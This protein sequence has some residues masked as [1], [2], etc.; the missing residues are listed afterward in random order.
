MRHE[1]SPNEENDCTQLLGPSSGCSN[2]TA[3]W[4]ILA[5]SGS[6]RS[7]S[8]NAKLLRAA[9]A[10][11][12]G[13]VSV[14]IYTG[15]SF[16]P[17]FNP[18]LDRQPAPPAVADLRFR[19][20]ECDAVVISSPEY[21][22][23]IPGVLKNALD[24]VVSSGELYGKPVGLF[25]ASPRATFAQAA[26]NE[27][28]GVMGANIITEACIMVPLSGAQGDEQTVISDAVTATRIREA[29]VVVVNA[30]RINFP[31]TSNTALK[32]IE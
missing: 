16:I 23:G 15:L 10:L 22:H 6:L 32:R 7:G 4:R 31:E 11:A 21:S 27:T 13:D 20:R 3:R 17:P 2:E 29:L 18:D 9:A 8:S 5:I 26:L 25:N 28:L 1:C 30:S 14:L 12:R 24:W 19:L